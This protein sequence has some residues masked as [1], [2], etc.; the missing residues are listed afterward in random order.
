MYGR[1]S[2]WKQL[3]FQVCKTLVKFKKK[4]YAVG[5]QFVVR[6]LSNQ[7][8]HLLTSHQMNSFHVDTKKAPTLGSRK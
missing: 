8:Q 4:L 5:I 2:T 6:I 1:V 7:Y 3:N